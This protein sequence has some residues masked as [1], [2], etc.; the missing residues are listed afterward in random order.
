MPVF[1]H[2]MYKEKF[3]K[4]EI[5]NLQL[6][7]YES[8]GWK[9]SK[10]L[11]NVLNFSVCASFPYTQNWNWLQWINLEKFDSIVHLIACYI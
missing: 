6:R 4:R 7:K 8:T 2:K 11:S 3:I 10:Q 9:V 5:V 1:I